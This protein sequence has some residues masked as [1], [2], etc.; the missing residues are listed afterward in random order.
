MMF[1]DKAKVKALMILVVEQ[2]TE[3]HV[4]ALRV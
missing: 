2:I 4:R 3:T 1:G